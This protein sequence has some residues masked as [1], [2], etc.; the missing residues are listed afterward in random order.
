[1]VEPDERYPAVTPDYLIAGSKGFMPEL[2]Q[3][4]VTWPQFKAAVLKL[5][6][7]TTGVKGENKR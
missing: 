1:V 2:D 7:A 5:R 6:L 4:L 3:A